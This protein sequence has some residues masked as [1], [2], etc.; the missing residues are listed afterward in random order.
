M[1][2]WG[3]EIVPVGVFGVILGAGSVVEP[4]ASVGV[5]VCEGVVGGAEMVVEVGI[6]GDVDAKVAVG[7]GV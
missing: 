2:S 4:T 5:R 6:G 1:T 7:K 3:R